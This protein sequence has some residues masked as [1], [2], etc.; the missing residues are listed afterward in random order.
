MAQISAEQEG[1]PTSS[2]QRPRFPVAVPPFW[3][4]TVATCQAILTDRFVVQIATV[5][6]AYLVAG[7]LGQE[8]ANIRSGNLGPVWPAYG[9]ALA[10]FLAYGYR[11]WVAVAASAFLVAVLSPVPP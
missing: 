7:K 10:A 4:P 3:W 2:S 6:L 5:F 1:V 9:V 11:I 8:T